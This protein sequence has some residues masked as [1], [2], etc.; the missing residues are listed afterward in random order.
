[1]TGYG[2]VEYEESIRSYRISNSLGKPWSRILCK[3]LRSFKSYVKN[4]RFFHESKFERI[5]RQNE[6]NVKR[7]YVGYTVQKRLWN[8]IAG[9]ISSYGR[10]LSV[11]TVRAY[12]HTY[13]HMGFYRNK[14]QISN[15]IIQSHLRINQKTSSVRTRRWSMRPIWTADSLIDSTS[16]KKLRHFLL[17]S[18]PEHDWSTKRNREKHA[19]AIFK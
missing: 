1:M 4:V 9:S 19:H 11:N 12:L 17:S 2:Y 6:M 7:L 8:T 15:W 14:S 16:A 3:C 18:A 13:V 5:L 10:N